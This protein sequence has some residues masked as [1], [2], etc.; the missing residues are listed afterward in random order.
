MWQIIVTI[1]H[2]FGLIIPE[3]NYKAVFVHDAYQNL[4][5]TDNL[6]TRGF[7]MLYCLCKG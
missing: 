2:F 6:R 4:R 7:C 1:V 3:R 5:D